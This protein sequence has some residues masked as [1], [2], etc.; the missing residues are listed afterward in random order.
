[1]DLFHYDPSSSPLLQAATDLW[2]GDCLLHSYENKCLKKD[3]NQS[4][5]F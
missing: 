1:M 2:L 4:S 5:E 3:H